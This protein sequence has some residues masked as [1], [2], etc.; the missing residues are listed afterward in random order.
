MLRLV[1]AIFT[2]QR[3]AKM[4]Q[5][6]EKVWIDGEL[7]DWNSPEAKIHLVTATLHYGRGVFEGIRFY[8]AK[9]KKAIF[10]LADHVGRLFASASLE[11]LKIPYTEV[12]LQDAI[13]QTVAANNFDAGYIRPLIFVGSGELGLRA[14]NGIVHAAILVVPWGAYHGEDAL[15][16]GIRLMTSSFVRTQN[17]LPKSKACGNYIL[18]YRALDEARARDFDDALLLDECGLVA[19][20]STSNIF[21][22]KGGKLI[23]PPLSSPILAGITRDTIITVARDYGRKAYEREISPRKLRRADECFLCGTAAEIT[24]VR[25][26][27]GLIFGPGTTG[28]ITGYLQWAYR[29]IVSG[30]NSRYNHWLTYV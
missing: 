9:N 21:I 22:V 13:I 1:R 12:G 25:E 27:D 14:K 20:A 3:S 4:A 15:R 26:I 10:R 19:E 28:E 2:N 18:S 6:G 30:R 8:A 23:T 16:K 29:E 24:P 7:V 17:M 5:P 11:N